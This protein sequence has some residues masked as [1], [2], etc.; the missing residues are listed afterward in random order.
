LP[1]AQKTL[2]EIKGPTATHFASGR[3][4]PII[5]DVIKTGTAVLGVS[6]EEDLSEIKSVCY[7]KSSV[8]GNL[9]GVTMRHW[10]AAEA[11]KEV[12]NAIASAGKGGGFILSDNHGEIPFQV[13]DEV[14]FA[15]SESAHKWGKYPLTWVQND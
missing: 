15:I 4:L 6:A 1:I 2:A 14:L 5:N 8:L 11:E 7:G 9:N 12:K 10:T 13:P 3:C